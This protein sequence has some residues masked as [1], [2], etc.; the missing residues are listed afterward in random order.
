MTSRDTD[1]KNLRQSFEAMDP[2]KAQA[3]RQAFYKA[4]E[5]LTALAEQLEDTDADTR[6]KG[7]LDEHLTA[8]QTLDTMNQSLLGKIL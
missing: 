2:A 4:I 5:G 7:L 1:D 3:I 6:N 8:A